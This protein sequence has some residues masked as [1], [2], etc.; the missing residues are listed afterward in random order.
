NYP[1]RFLAGQLSAVGV[2][3]KY[4]EILTGQDGGEIYEV[5]TRGARV[6]VIDRQEPTPGNDLN[7]TIDAE[8]SKVAYEALE[9]RPGAV[10]VSR[11]DSGQVLALVSSPSFD[12]HLFIYPQVSN[13][14]HSRGEAGTTPGDEEILALF[15]DVQ[16]P[17]FNRSI[18][19]TYPPGSTFKIVS[20]TAGLEEEKINGQTLIED[21]GVIKVGAYSYSNWLFTKYGRTEGEINVVRAIQRSTDTFFY[22]VGEMLGAESLGNW[23]KAF[24]LGRLTEIDLEGEVEGLVPSPDWKEEVI[25]ERWFLGNTYHLAIGQGDLLLTPL[26]VNMMMSVVANDGW[27]CRPSLMQ[28]AKITRPRPDEVKKNQN[29]NVKIKNNCKDLQL[30]A[31]TLRLVKEGLVGACSPGGTAEIFFE[32]EPQV[33]CK[34]GTAEFGPV[35]ASGYRDTHAWLTAFV[36]ADKPEIVVTALVEGGGEGSEVAAPIVK[37]VIEKWFEE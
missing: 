30:K 34:T 2:E 11:A 7:L 9:G 31:E 13:I 6:R 5:D 17:M 33:A 27:L 15:E 8:L 19:G 22:K 29:E 37:K 35:K 16:K 26:Q 32:F 4:N 3:Q 18:G 14:F 25:G 24:G 23:A 20:A 36:P 21:T 28:N 12:P 10:V 1:G